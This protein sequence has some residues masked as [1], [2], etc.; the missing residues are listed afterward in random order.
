M[1]EVDSPRKRRFSNPEIRIKEEGGLQRLEYINFHN[2]LRSSSDTSIVYS[3]VSAFFHLKSRRKV[4]PMW[5]Q[6]QEYFIL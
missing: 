6:M 1:R 4:V 5:T 3:V 2:S